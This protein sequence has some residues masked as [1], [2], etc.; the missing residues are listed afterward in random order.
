MGM[1]SDWGR[2]IARAGGVALVLPAAFVLALLLTVAIG[3]GDSLRALGQVV[4]GPAAPAATPTRTEPDLAAAVRVPALRVAR[5]VP[6]VGRAPSAPT[7]RQVFS[8]PRHPAH[9]SPSPSSPAP[10]RPTTPSR[11]RPTPQPSGG[12]GSP[13]PPPA[14]PTAPV[15]QIAQQV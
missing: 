11:P 9:H 2:G 12:G 10:A 1:V 5:T 7:S 6:V 15:K 8:A 14:S 13:S 3:G 4:A